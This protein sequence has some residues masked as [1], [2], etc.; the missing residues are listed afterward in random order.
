MLTFGPFGHAG[1][2]STDRPKNGPALSGHGAEA[3]RDAIACRSIYLAQHLRPSQ[4]WDQGAVTAR[5]AELK[6]LAGLPAYTNGPID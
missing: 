4:T 2:K 1:L 6:I 5:Y 3:V